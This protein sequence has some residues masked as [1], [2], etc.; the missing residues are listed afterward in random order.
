[1]YISKLLIHTYLQCGLIVGS[2][3][4][5]GA[6]CIG[7]EVAS[8]YFD[9]VESTDGPKACTGSAKEFPAKNKMSKAS[10][11]VQQAIKMLITTEGCSKI[12]K[13]S[14]GWYV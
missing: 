10:R 8:S 13:E 14:Q 9:G 3:V 7:H 12:D 5:S 4:S 2:L 11:H 1:M 6:L